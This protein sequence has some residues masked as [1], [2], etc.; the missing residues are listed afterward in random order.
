MKKFAGPFLFIALAFFFLPT[1]L[2]AQDVG[3]PGSNYDPWSN[4]AKGFVQ[5]HGGLA[6]LPIMTINANHLDSDTSISDT[7]GAHAR[8]PGLAAGLGLIPVFSNNGIIIEAAYAIH[9]AEFKSKGER[10]GATFHGENTFGLSLVDAHTGSSRYFLDG[11]WHLYV[12]ALVGLQITYVKMNSKYDN[13]DSLISE[14]RFY[15]MSTGGAFGFF[16]SYRTGGLG[17]E[18]RV[19]STVLP[20]KVKLD[21]AFGQ[22]EYTLSYPMQIKLVA[23]F[24]LGGI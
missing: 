7:W 18:L 1:A 12:S 4:P 15:N 14:D 6:Y 9:G 5:I 3:L 13:E 21:D 24:Q 23:I 20:T 8:F 19:E 17:A 16:S 2:F 10:A 11:P 22:V